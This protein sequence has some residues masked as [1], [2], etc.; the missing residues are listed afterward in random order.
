MHVLHS[1]LRQYLSCDDGRAPA[2]Q[3]PQTPQQPLLLRALR[4]ALSFAGYF[5]LGA[6]LWIAGSAAVRHAAMSGGGNQA[7]ATPCM[8]PSSVSRGSAA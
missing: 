7:R 6:A 3:T 4:S 2:Q 5:L 8:V 1:S